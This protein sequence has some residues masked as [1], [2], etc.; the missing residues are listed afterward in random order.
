[1]ELCDTKGCWSTAVAW[2]LDTSGRAPER[3]H[4]CA[5]CRRKFDAVCIE[6]GCES[7]AVSFRRCLKCVKVWGLKGRSGGR[8]LEPGL[9]EASDLRRTSTKK[10][11]AQKSASSSA[12]KNPPALSRSSI[13]NGS[14]ADELDKWDE[15]L[16]ALDARRAEIL[17]AQ[18]RLT[19][20]VS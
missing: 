16:E 7:E 15:E 13:S 5:G 2:V 6:P 9:V 14:A 3:V 12:P 8:A 11:P 17:E 19:R 4:V 10:V 1:M 18:R 20:S